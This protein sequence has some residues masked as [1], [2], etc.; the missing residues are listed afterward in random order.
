MISAFFFPFHRVKTCSSVTSRACFFPKANQAYRELVLGD[1][2]L[3]VKA[4][5]AGMA[6]GR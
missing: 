5:T 3:A 6:E 1:T 2:E 4:V